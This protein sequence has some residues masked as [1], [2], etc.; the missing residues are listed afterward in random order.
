MAKRATILMTEFVTHDVK[1]FILKKPRGFEFVPGQGTLIAINKPDLKDDA[2]PFTPTS[3]TEDRVLEFTIKIH[4]E[5]HG[6]TERLAQLRPG[7]ELLL[8]PVFGTIQYKGPGVFIAG[9]AG[10]TPFIAMLRRLARD[11]GL[12]GNTL[13][14]SNKTRD[15]VILEKELRA[16]LGERCILT[17]TGRPAAGYENRMID[18]AFLKEKVGRFDQPFYLCGPP[19]MVQALTETLRTLGAKPDNVVFEQ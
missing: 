9:G 17:L 6:L 13:L 10:I 1:R 14:F 12:A 8:G 16:C 2:H 15:D 4:P 18:A 3:L 19:P 7:D 11:G 5:H